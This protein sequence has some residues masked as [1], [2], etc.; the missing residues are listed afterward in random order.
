MTS[1]CLSVTSVTKEYAGFTAVWELSFTARTGEFVCI[2]G[3][4]G[5]G[6]TTL[7][8]LVA[9]LDAP[10]SG[11]ISMDG[12]HVVGPS[13]L[14]GMIFQEYAL[15]T[16][17]TVINNVAFGLE[18]KGLAKQ[19]REYIARKYVDLV[20]LKAF[21]S[22]YPHELS[23]G[24]KQRVGIARL[25]ANNPTVILADEPFGA[26]DALTRSQMQDEFLR[27]WEADRKTILFVTHSIEEAVFLADKVVLMSARTRSLKRVVHVPLTRPRNRTDPDF[28]ALRDQIVAELETV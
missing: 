7:L 14:R 8:R 17:R 20:G 28:S 12:E 21:A 10:T 22:N 18:V 11:T 6:K 3:P 9:G 15:F 13:S 5:C 26:L 27:I 25:L 19:E 24:M 4:S 23:G 2:V 16:W 1:G